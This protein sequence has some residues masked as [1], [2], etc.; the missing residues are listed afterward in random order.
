MNPQRKLIVTAALVVVAAG[1]L[2][3]SLKPKASPLG[4][5]AGATLSV[6][7]ACGHEETRTLKSVPDVCSACQK[8]ETYPAVKC[9]GCGA[10]NALVMTGGPQGR[11]PLL[12]CRSCGRQFAPKR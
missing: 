3:W 4:K 1:V 12:T 5:R 10:A 7:A 2:A 6:C 11:P 8:Q 9:P